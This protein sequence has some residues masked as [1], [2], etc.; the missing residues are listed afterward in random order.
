[1]KNRKENP[2]S[3]SWDKDIYYMISINCKYRGTIHDLLKEL[4]QINQI[5]KDL[6]VRYAKLKNDLI[7]FKPK[8]GNYKAVK[9][10]VVDELFSKILNSVGI[11]IP[12]KRLAA[13][14]YLFGTR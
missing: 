5:R 1:M 7:N 8:G 4:R 2:N 13:G 9:G 6:D 10:D 3:I 12:V 14:K 11:N